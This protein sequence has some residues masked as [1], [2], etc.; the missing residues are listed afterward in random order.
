MD[1][2]FCAICYRYNKWAAFAAFADRYKDEIG[3]ADNNY[4]LGYI[5]QWHGDDLTLDHHHGTLVPDWD[6][7]VDKLHSQELGLN[8]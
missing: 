4:G 5:G 2:N 6:R 7:E 8:T 3:A 1:I